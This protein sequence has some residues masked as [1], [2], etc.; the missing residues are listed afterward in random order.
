[1]HIV[2]VKKTELLSVLKANRA[3]HREIVDEA[4]AA[5][6][7]RA[8]AELD[9]MIAEAKAGKRIRRGITLVEPIDQTKEYDQAIRKLEMSV[10]KI[11]EID[12]EDFK[13]LVCDDWRWKAQFTASNSFYSSKAQEG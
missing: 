1:M 3:K 9:S 2:K 5:Y 10:E 8:I 7:T 11:I 12:E 4:L 6:R 13:Q